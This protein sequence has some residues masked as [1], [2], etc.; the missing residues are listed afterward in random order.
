MD[1]KYLELNYCFVCGSPFYKNTKK[2]GCRRRFLQRKI[3]VRGVRNVTCSKDCSKKYNDFIT[4]LSQ[5]KKTKANELRAK[6][7]YNM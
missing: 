2:K 4:K 1:S 5:L 3:P 6:R 7:M